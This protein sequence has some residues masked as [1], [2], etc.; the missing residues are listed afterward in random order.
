MKFVPLAGALGFAAASL[1]TSREASA[2]AG[3][4][5]PSLAISRGSDGPLDAAALRL[6]VSLTGTAVHVVHEAGCADPSA[7]EEVPPQALHLHDQR[8]YP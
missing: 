7:C 5:N 3:C 2:C 1:L 6:G 4:R 8:L